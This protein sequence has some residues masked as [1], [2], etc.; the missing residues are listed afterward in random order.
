MKLKDFM[1]ES[2]QT[3]YA[4]GVIYSLNNDEKRLYQKIKEAGKVLKDEL[5]EFDVRVVNNLVTRGL[6]KR[7]KNPQHEIYFTAKGRRKNIHKETMT[8][9]APPDAE[10]ESWV[11]ANKDSFKEKYGKQYGKYLYGKAWNKFNGKKINESY[12]HRRRSNFANTGVMYDDDYIDFQVG[13]SF[14]DDKD[15]KWTIQKIV[16]NTLVVSSEDGHRATID[17]DTLHTYVFLLDKFHMV[18]DDKFFDPEDAE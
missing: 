3:V 6:I 5:P 11:E 17:K 4:N 10:I 1:V 12:Y 14:I 16:D 18:F 7:K 8:E 2:F 13:M 15:V 9:V